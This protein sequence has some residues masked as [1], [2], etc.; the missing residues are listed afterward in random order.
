[1]HHDGLARF[2]SAFGADGAAEAL[3][4]PGAC[5]LFSSKLTSW[6]G[7][8]FGYASKYLHDS[9]TASLLPTACG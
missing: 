6:N 8:P 9:L 3:L 2:L 4:L 7:A 1:M 5:Y